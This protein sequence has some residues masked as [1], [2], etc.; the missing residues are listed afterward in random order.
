MEKY[1]E[2]MDNK[3]F[4]CFHM[5]Y[6]NM[7]TQIRNVLKIIHFAVMEVNQII[8]HIKKLFNKFYMFLDLINFL[9]QLEDE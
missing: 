2:F 6:K 3:M 8:E 1:Y 5:L 9:L 4:L 7:Q